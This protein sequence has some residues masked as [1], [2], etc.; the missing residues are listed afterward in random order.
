ML[1]VWI[2]APK[3]GPEHYSGF[4]RS[5]L[6]PELSA[7]EKIQARAFANPVKSK[8]TRLFNLQKYSRF[9]REL[10]DRAEH[11]RAMN[12]PLGGKP[13]GAGE[14]NERKVI[15]A[16]HYAV[17]AILAKIFGAPFWFF[18]QWRGRVADRIDSEG[19]DR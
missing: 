13:P 8:V 9:Y 17:L 19:S 1:P 2:R 14:L 3:S 5:K 16:A 11:E 15:A 6:D 12:A 7:R 18:E 4:T 10:R